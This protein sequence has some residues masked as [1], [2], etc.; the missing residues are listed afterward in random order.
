MPSSFDCFENEFP[1]LAKLG[2]FAE[3]YCYSDPN[4][5]LYKIRKI[6]E[7]I[8]SLIYEYDNLPV[9][10]GSVSGIPQASRINALQD[11]GII[12]KLL[13]KSFTRL[14]KIGNEAVHE[15]LDSSILV[16]ELLPISYS[17]CFWFAETYGTKENQASK[18]Y[19]APKNL[20]PIAKKKV[21]I[22]VKRP[23]DFT[24]QEKT[25]EEN[26]N[27]LIEI[28]KEAAAAAP[29]VKIELRRN[30][31]FKANRARPLTEAETRELIDEQLRSVGWECDT[32][33]L[34][35]KLFGTKPQKGHNMAIAEWQTDSKIYN[36]GYADY[37]LF[38]G[39]K[40][41]AVIEAKAH[42]KDIP[43][44]IDGQCKE[45]ASL[46]KNADG[47][48]ISGSWGINKEYKVPLAFATNGRPY[49]KQLETKSGIWFIDF[50][51]P[52]QA[53]RALQGWMSPIGISELLE[54]DSTKV[55]QIKIDDDDF[56]RNKDGLSLREYQIEAIHAVDKALAEGKKQM[57]LAMATGTG[58]TRT[59]LALIYRFLKSGRFKRILLLVD[60]NSLGKQAFD[61]FSEV[62]LD[63]LQPL[64]D[65]YNIK[66]LEEKII[67]RE[68]KLQISTVQG[69]VQRVLYNDG[70]RMP[71]VTD[72]D[73]VIID[74]AHRGY[75]LDKEMADEEILF[76]DQLDYQSKYRNIIEY[77]DAVKIGFTATPA[78]QTTQIFGEPVY[79][80][81][82]RRAVYEGYLCDHDVPY[83]LSTAKSRE[84]IHFK[85]GE[86]VPKY[87]P[88]THEIV[89]E[90]VLPDE[91]NYDVEK[92]NDQIVVPDFNKKVFDELTEK[93]LILDSPDS[94]GKT[95]VFAVNDAHADTIVDVL[96]KICQ[97]KGIP[98]NAVMKITGAAGGGN[99]KK[100]EELIK[101]FKNEPYPSIVVTVDLLTT[102]IDVPPITNLV[103]MRCVKSRIL[104]EQMLGRA[105]RLCPEIHKEKFNI[106]DPV[107]IYD[108]L[109]EVINMKPVV[110]Q[111]K[112]KMTEL[113]ESLKETTEPNVVLFQINQLV[114]KLQRKKN[115][116]TDKAIA[117]F[118]T[119][120][121][122]K[123]VDSYIS[124]ILDLSPADA[125]AKI[126]EDEKLF[127]LIENDKAAAK[128]IIIDNTD[129][130]DVQ[131]TRGYGKHNLKEPQDYLEEFSAF[132]RDNRDKIT[133]LNIV[134]TK[135][136]S[137]TRE[138]LKSLCVQLANE[139]YDI[140]SLN[141]AINNATNA[142][143]TVD[144]INVIRS[145]GIGSPLLSHEDRIHRAFQKLKAKHNFTPVEQH[146][147]TIIESNLMVENTIDESIFDTEVIFRNKGGFKRIDKEFNFQLK[148]LINELNIYLYEDVA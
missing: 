114:A 86:I 137:L 136:A 98:E 5:A 146:W 42:H 27:K 50:R 111:P 147:L 80:Y 139:G 117:D 49:L 7:T 89:N 30:R 135:P 4:S 107:G 138:S 37:A 10:T 105:T 90:A 123:S 76:R 82:Y 87:D 77:F 125:K 18:E 34:N 100:I 127:E 44:V 113:V 75:I 79:T 143:M 13:A 55:E 78:L 126:I 96:K 103:F 64:T 131:V 36:H 38:I 104:F 95:L 12:N 65:I 84:G 1:A 97:Q 24:V 99:Q 112:I 41:V 94:F 148:A 101:S 33:T 63:Q 23:Q 121:G 14:R 120:S 124:K 130:G 28:A 73:L 17:L 3:N 43:C 115:N 22:R 11:Y 61:V 119:L 20:A 132:I 109:K 6:G 144:I 29:K 88:N 71:A 26:E 56:L 40:L 68:T 16:E 74:E 92:F 70:A 47:Q 25:E 32:N 106:F 122:E 81:S 69:M 72:F 8:T 140:N 141:T 134:C 133:A 2:K 21:I 9:P 53:P 57:L 48:Y 110:Q 59:F 108:A 31:S 85:E 66:N 19:T 15:D 116:L 52:I 51:N 129:D 91:L 54:K 46:I 83:M 145:Y 128:K 60:R 35:Q 45:Y 62:K 39:E 118:K 93:Y 67:D 102:G 142:D 58:K